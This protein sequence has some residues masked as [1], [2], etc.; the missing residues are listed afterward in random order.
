M[1]GFPAGIAM[2]SSSPL[3]VGIGMWERRQERKSA[4]EQANRNIDAQREF[5]QHGVRWRVE[6]AK[7]AG[8]HPLFAL[9]GAGAAFA[10]NP[11]TV[12]SS[13]LGAGLERMGQNLSSAAA[14]TMTVEQ[15]NM[16]LMQLKAMEANVARDTAQ[17]SYYS[18]LEAKTRQ[19]MGAGASFPSD[20]VT[21]ASGGR[22]V[23][24]PTSKDGGRTRLES[25]PLF[26]DAVKLNPDD[27]ISRS[28]SDPGVTASPG[29][30]SLSWFNVPGVGWVLLPPGDQGKFPEDMSLA[31]YVA[32]IAGN[33][34]YGAR[35]IKRWFERLRNERNW[36][37]HSNLRRQ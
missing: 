27:Q 4:E 20:V 30:P 23:V 15:R 21:D 32:A 33:T 9:G 8:L 24:S 36:D 35:A 28:L 22:V 7:A 37:E 3:S 6:D 34:K 12:G 10:P 5:A 1:A 18:A 13:G 25:H 29:K 2:P 17:A 26:K 16:H 11:I 14:R 19:E 31:G